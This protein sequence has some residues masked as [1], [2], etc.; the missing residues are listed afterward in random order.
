MHRHEVDIRF[1]T[2]GKKANT[3]IYQTI[4]LKLTA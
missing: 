1:I 2:V 4:P 3:R